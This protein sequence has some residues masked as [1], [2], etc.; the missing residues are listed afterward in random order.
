MQ[1][2]TD[3]QTNLKSAV[4][5]NQA[6]GMKSCGSDGQVKGLAMHPVKQW[7]SGWR[8]ACVGQS[9]SRDRPHP[10]HTF[11]VPCIAAGKRA[12]LSATQARQTDSG[13]Q[14]S[15]CQAVIAAAAWQ[16]DSAGGMPQVSIH[17]ASRPCHACH[18]AVDARPLCRCCTR[19][20]SSWRWC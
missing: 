8:R 20:R 1:S 4:S 11:E 10:A 12:S 5:S 14:A 17:E 7:M 16:G 9:L 3:W 6:R 2:G 13:S 15:I 18:S 19:Q